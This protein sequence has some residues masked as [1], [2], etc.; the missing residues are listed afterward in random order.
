[1]FQLCRYSSMKILHCLLASPINER[2]SSVERLSVTNAYEGRCH[3]TAGKRQPSWWLYCTAH[4]SSLGHL[5]PRARLSLLRKHKIR[6]WLAHVV[7]SLIYIN[8]VL[9][10]AS[11]AGNASRRHCLINN[12]NVGQCHTTADK[13]QPSWL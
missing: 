4:D 1:M 7:S 13:R 9:L 2:F 6:C 8:Q 10:C 5:C 11:R 3:S 12:T